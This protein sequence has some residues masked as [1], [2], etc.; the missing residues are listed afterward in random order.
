[1][2]G[3]YKVSLILISNFDTNSTFKC[4]PILNH[5]VFFQSSNFIEAFMAKSKISLGKVT[6]HLKICGLGYSQISFDIDL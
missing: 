1:M 3:I 6:L 2:H 5:P 4:F